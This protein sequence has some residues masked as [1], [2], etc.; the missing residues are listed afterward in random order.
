[1]SKRASKVLD[2]I[3]IEMYKVAVPSLDLKPY[4]SRERPT[5]EVDYNKHWLPREIQ[6]G[7]EWRLCKENKIKSYDRERIHTSLVL[8]ASPNTCY[9]QWYINMVRERFNNTEF[10]K[11]FKNQ[12][13][14]ALK[15][16]SYSGEFI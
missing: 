3:L 4:L 1:M 6:T 11:R 13:D 5:D 12:I 16:G 9:R 2:E 14:D 7:I 10:Y 15:W 8:G